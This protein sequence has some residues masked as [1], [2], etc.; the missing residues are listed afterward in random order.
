MC[1]QHSLLVTLLCVCLHCTVSS[2]YTSVHNLATHMCTQLPYNCH[3]HSLW[4]ARLR[5]AKV[6]CRTSWIVV[7]PA[8]TDLETRLDDLVFYFFHSIIQCKTHGNEKFEACGV[9][10]KELDMPVVPRTHRTVRR[11]G[12]ISLRQGCQLVRWGSVSFV[13]LTDRFPGELITR[14][15]HITDE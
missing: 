14:L 15:F 12:F 8:L 2:A 11:P 9:K 1:L 13:C 4:C 7:A 3:L 10:V 5:H 6:A